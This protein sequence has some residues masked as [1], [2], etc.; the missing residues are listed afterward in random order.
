MHEST[1]QPTAARSPTL[2][3]VT[4]APTFVTRP[5]ISWPGT[6]GYTVPGHSLRAACRSEWQM[7]QKRMSIWT[8]RGPGS[9]RSRSKGRNREVLSNAGVGKGFTHDATYC[10]IDGAVHKR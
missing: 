10:D 6:H 4:E 7:P 5:A 8:S 2:K 9:R 1:M 3:P